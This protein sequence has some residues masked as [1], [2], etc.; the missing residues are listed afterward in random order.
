[1]RLRIPLKS[2]RSSAA[3]T[4][5]TISTTTT[6]P[7]KITRRNTP[8]TL[9]TKD[10]P[11]LDDNL[12]SL[13][14]VQFTTPSEAASEPRPPSSSRYRF[15]F[16]R[17]TTVDFSQL[18]SDAPSPPMQR[19]IW[20][21]RPGASST[22]VRVNEDDL[23]D[24]VRDV[25]LHKYANSLGRSI[26]AP[27][28][29]LK[30][31]TREQNKNVPSE[32]QLGPEEAI[33]QTLDTYYPGGQ[34]IEEALIIEVPQRRTPRASPRVGNH[35]IPYYYADEYR[36]SENARDYFSPMP[37]QSP[38]LAPNNLYQPSMAV[39]TTGQL[40][41]LPSPGAQQLRRSNRPKYGRQHTSSPTI[42]HTTQPSASALGEF[43][44][45]EFRQSCL[46]P[47]GILII[48]V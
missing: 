47:S 2:G 12:A 33:G 41:P 16:S 22:R 48:S 24:N 25:I 9:D 3:S 32:R 20:V 31:I 44:I 30:I 6:T 40:P 10:I 37:L 21:R 8:T 13:S 26:D 39:L 7:D 38:H 4:S 43:P 18:S 29:T 14:Q 11:I 36:P 34:T 1:M 27:D 5:T 15:P 45:N 42:L 17:R 19:N 46:C 23:V 28:I 35:T